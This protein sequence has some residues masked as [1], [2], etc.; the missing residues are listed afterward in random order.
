[1]WFELG[2][3]I[4]WYIHGYECFGGAFWFCL[5]RPWDDG[6]SRS[7]PNRVCWPFR[8]H[9]PINEKAAISNLHMIHFPCIV[10]LCYKNSCA[11]IRQYTALL[12]YIM[13]WYE[14]KWVTGNII[15]NSK[16]YVCSIVI[17][18]KAYTFSFVP[19]RTE[20]EWNCDMAG[21]ALTISRYIVLETTTNSMSQSHASYK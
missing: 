15:K 6:S 10:S 12:F 4:V 11:H 3:R 7:R 5:H 8:L 14:Q 2:H 21:A 19:P 17:I 20:R 18:L 1:M 16:V 9:G 13:L